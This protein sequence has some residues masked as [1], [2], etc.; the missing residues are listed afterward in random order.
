M[1]GGQGGEESQIFLHR[2]KSLK[3]AEA[4]PNQTVRRSKH[5]IKSQCSCFPFRVDLL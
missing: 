4:L 3:C 2:E 5:F 1:K